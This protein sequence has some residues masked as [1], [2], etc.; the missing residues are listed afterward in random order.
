MS[1]KGFQDSKQWATMSQKN[2]ATEMS[3]EDRLTRVAVTHIGVVG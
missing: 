3:G 1:W 2:Y